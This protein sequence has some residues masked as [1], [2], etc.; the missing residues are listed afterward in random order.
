MHLIAGVVWARSLA[1]MYS[2]QM[3][4]IAAGWAGGFG[5]LCMLRFA[6]P[7][8][9]Y[10]SEIQSACQDDLATRIYISRAAK[11]EALDYMQS[12]RT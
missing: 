11:T 3:I 9:I 7:S 12:L 1:R 4:L 8:Q 2:Y 10:A 6:F 5:A